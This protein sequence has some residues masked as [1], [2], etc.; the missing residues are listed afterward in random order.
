MIGHSKAAVKQGFADYN[1][2]GG[3]ITLLA[4]TW[5]P[6]TNDGAGGFTN[7]LFLPDGVTRL[8]NTST[9]EIDVSELSLGDAIIIRQDYTVTQGANNSLLEARYSLGT[10]GGAYTLTTL[11]QRLDD[12]TGTTYRFSLT[13]DMIYMGDANTRDNPICFELKLE[14]AGSVVNAG[15]AIYVVKR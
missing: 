4:D 11:K 1:N 9:G 7:E 14:N 3:A 6:I 8:M 15:T 12:G 5:T 10:G 13:T 2:A